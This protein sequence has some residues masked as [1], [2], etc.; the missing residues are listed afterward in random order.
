[1]KANAASVIK[2]QCAR[3]ITDQYLFFQ[4]RTVKTANPKVKTVAI[5]GRERNAI[6]NAGTL[7]ASF[8]APYNQSDKG[9][10]MMKTKFKVPTSNLG[11]W[12]KCVLCISWTVSSSRMRD[13]SQ[14]PRSN[15]KLLRATLSQTGHGQPGQRKRKGKNCQQQAM[16]QLSTK[17]SSLSHS[18]FWKSNRFS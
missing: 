18:L 16:N 7:Y 9:K 11:W 4:P 8:H 6:A 1:M 12:A 10:P 2:E 14:R 13:F 15:G 17:K 5:G 3:A